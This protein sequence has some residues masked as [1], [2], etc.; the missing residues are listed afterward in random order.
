MK[1]ELRRLSEYTDDALLSELRRVAD[2]V[3]GGRFTI[4]E[5]SKHSKVG[6]TTLRRRFGS[7]PKALE[8][9][10]LA[11][12]Y[13]AP[14]PAAKSRVL[15]RSLSND[16]I[17]LEIH[18]V[19]KV[20]GATNLTADDLRQ[21]AAVGVDAIRNRFGTLK[22]ALR[23]AGVLETAHGR[24]Y[25]DEQCFENLLNVWTHY[26]RPPLYQEM[27]L[28]P[29]AVGPKAYIV[30]WKTWNRALQAFADRVSEDRE[31]SS[32][33][34]GGQLQAEASKPPRVEVP[35]EDRHKIKLALRYKV[36]VRDRFKCALCGASPA[37]NPDCCLHVDHI[38]PWSKGGKTVIQNLRALC[39]S[40]NL[41]KGNQSQAESA[42]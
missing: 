24:R 33:T 23:A 30:R 28:I 32:A 20:T 14:A 29:S 40:C 37:T 31:E 12:L 1:F 39:E 22:A 41:G 2:V 27:K 16:Q 6:L 36:L 35:E 10:G 18:R 42:G 26:G 17:L 38:I 15:A 7:W 34:Q 8:A 19:A 25:T 4:S 13:N 21:H 5:F 3:G 11:H 9:A